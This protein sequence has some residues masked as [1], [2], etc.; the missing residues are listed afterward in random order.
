[1]A[2]VA[3]GKTGGLR[4]VRAWLMPVLA[5]SVLASCRTPSFLCVAPS[6][7]RDLTIKTDSG[8]NNGQAIDIDLLYFTNKDALKTVEALKARDYFAQKE[9]LR[10]N[11]PTEFKRYEFGFEPTQYRDAE[12]GKNK[13]K[14]QRKS[15]KIQ[16]PCNLAGTLLFVDYNNDL[17]DHRVNLTKTKKFTLVLGPDDFKTPR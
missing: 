2:R 7:L 1:M 17:T 12:I 16:P 5:L 9:Q 8:S 10:R 3:T 15:Y 4:T 14:Q 6:G 13:T 11:Y